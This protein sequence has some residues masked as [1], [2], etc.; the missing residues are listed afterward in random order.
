MNKRSKKI[1]NKINNFKKVNVVPNKED[2]RSVSDDAFFDLSKSSTFNDMEYD[3]QIKLKY[4]KVSSLFKQYKVNDVVVSPNKLGYRHKV[5]LSS[6]NIQTPH[7]NYKIKLGLY[8]EGS[9]TIIPDLENNMHDPEI[10]KIFQAIEKILQKY[11]IESYNYRN[12]RGV[13]KHVLI[14]KSY[15][16]KE[17][18]VVF[19]TQG[20]LLPNNRKIIKDLINENPNIKTVIQNI[21]ERETSIVILDKEQVLYGPGYIR[22]RIGNL[23]FR[24]SSQ[25]FYQVNPAQMIN[26][27]QYALD[28]ARID[29]NTTVLDTYSGIGTISLL[30]AEKAKQVYAVEINPEAHKDAIFNKGLNKIKNINFYNDDVIG[31]I[32]TFSEKID[33]LIM[34]PTREGASREFL[35][36]LN[37]MKPER[38]IYISCDPFTQAR[39]V[40]VLSSQY[41][42]KSIQPFDMFPSSAHIE[43][44]VV[45]ELKH[46]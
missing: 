27:Y 45:L 18:M 10:N 14:R 8:K 40:K 7:K 15:Y 34:D 33:V 35:E 41:E 1:N 22:D 31:F 9:K 32:K 12:P 6:T 26:M 21:H 24:I 43:N 42:I 29:S 37:L 20:N 16:N 13:I 46:K 44:V 23:D 2:E 5:I 4:D 28:E 11:K 38:I 39:D 30:A 17:F 19:V 3:L 25:A 36:T